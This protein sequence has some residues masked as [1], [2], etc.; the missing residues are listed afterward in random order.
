MP[1]GPL[2]I[3]FS[4]LFDFGTG[5]GILSILAE[6]LGASTIEAID[7]DHWSIENAEE[8]AKRND[9]KK[10]SFRLTAEIPQHPF[11]IVLANINRNV[12]LHHLETLRKISRQ[13]ILLSGL[14]TTDEEM[15]MEACKKQGLRLVRR[16]E[17]NNWICLLVENE[18]LPN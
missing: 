6:K 5:T 2:N 8:N 9:C 13:N 14:L 10:I 7:I 12:I 17:K 16:T 4:G 1:A 3:T 18:S 15:V 11:D